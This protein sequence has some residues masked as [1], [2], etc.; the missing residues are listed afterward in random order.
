MRI[1]VFT[2]SFEKRTLD[3]ILTWL[4][5]TAPEIADLEIG[6]GGYSP[7]PH[8]DLEAV[9]RDE[10]ER[11]AWIG[12]LAE[13]GF[14]VCALNVSGNP[15]EIESHDRDLR[16]TIEL[17]GLLGVDRVVCMSGGDPGLSAGG[18]FPDM[19]RQLDAYWRSTV[20]PYWQEIARL[21]SVQDGLHLCF[22]LEPGASVYN[23]ATF[24]RVAEGLPSLAV[25]LDPSH[26]FW[27]SMDPLETVRRLAGRIGFAHGK[28]TLLDPERVRVDGVLDRRSWRFATVGDGHDAGWW[29]S[30]VAALRAAS[31]D[32]VVSIEYEDPTRSPEESVVAA[33][34]V[35]VPALAGP[36]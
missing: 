1:G 35:L 27:Q 11:G 18:W 3:E 30:F 17:A 33:V 23:V 20:L 28:D 5:E 14:R 24:A 15:L 13:R 34:R 7:T 21:A 32:R 16:L 12:A 31:Y 6:T 2:D 25:N 22:E 29:M 19:E 26:L 8:C 9:I 10:T 36:A 4:E